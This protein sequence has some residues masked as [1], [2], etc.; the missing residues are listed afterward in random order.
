MNWLRAI[1]CCVVGAVGLTNL[2]A[3]AAA[4][5]N[6]SV[7]LAG[8]DVQLD[9]EDVLTYGFG[10]G[11]MGSPWTE[12][13][14]K[15]DG[16]ITRRYHHLSGKR[17]N[18]MLV[19][20]Q[21]ARFSVVE[22]LRIFQGLADRGLW[23]LQSR[24]VCC[25]IPGAWLSGTVDGRS[26]RLEWSAMHGG[27]PASSAPEI[28]ELFK[29]LLDHFARDDRKRSKDAQALK[30]SSGEQRVKTLPQTRRQGLKIEPANGAIVEPGKTVT[31]SVEVLSLAVP[32]DGVR[33]FVAGQ[34]PL[35]DRAAPYAFELVIPKESNGKLLNIEA[36]AISGSGPLFD[37]AT[38]LIH[39]GIQ[40]KSLL[41]IFA[42]LAALTALGYFT[43][44]NFLTAAGAG[45]ILVLIVLVITGYVS[46]RPETSESFSVTN[47]PTE[48]GARYER[49]QII[50]QPD[51]K[52][53]RNTTASSVQVI[54]E[55]D[56][57]K[58]IPG[59]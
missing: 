55:S 36:A 3:M 6:D 35:I 26:I 13:E 49:S 28:H 27:D 11:K 45:A 17:P 31:V 5:A 24:A 19:D 34:E 54:R 56:S 10:G 41:A 8:H 44:Q 1:A 21:T 33:L 29:P 32:K 58:K 16:R 48:T 47:T 40:R 43:G 4:K 15:G 30:P 46:I 2:P 18:E 59:K 38:Y 9:A 25:D 50:R 37:R 20:E 39:G 52:W 57:P 53:T 14:V 51:G 23:T 12:L 22:A 7:A 42:G